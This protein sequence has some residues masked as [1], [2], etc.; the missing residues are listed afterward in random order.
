MFIPPTVI[1]GLQL[2]IPRLAD[3]NRAT[4]LVATMLAAV[5]GLI[6]V[7]C[8]TSPLLNN[9]TP[10]KNQGVQKVNVVVSP[11]NATLSPSEIQQFTANVSGTANTAVIWSASAGFINSDGVYTAPASDSTDTVTINAISL[12]NSS[13]V[14][15]ATV[16]IQKK[17]KTPKPTIT[18]TSVAGGEQGS[19]YSQ[20][21]SASGG[22]QPY[23]WR[24][25][26]GSL[27]AGLTMSAD[28]QIAGVPTTAGTFSFGVSVTDTQ[29]ST[30]QQAY[31]L[32]IA[33]GTNFDG[34]AE[35]PRVYLN[36]AL[37][38][39]PAPGAVTP[40]AAG[41]DLQSVLNNANCGDTIALQAGATFT[42]AYYLRAKACDEQH[43]ITIRTNTAD[44]NLPSEGTRMTPCYA[45]VASLP[46]RPSYPCTA[47][48][49]VL[50]QILGKPGMSL[51]SID[52]GANHYRLIG[53]ELTRPVGTGETDAL[54]QASG[55]ADHLIFD[56]LWL[57]GT[58]HDDT[59]RGIYL[60]GV[61]NAAVVDSYFSDFHCTSVTGACTDSQDVSGGNGDYPGGPYKIVNNFL[62]AAAESILFGGGGATTTTPTDIEIR[63][64]HFFKPMTWLSGQPGFVGGPSGNAFV[65]KNHFEL[66]NASRVLL[67]GNILENTWGGFSQEGYSILMT[68]RSKVS[69][70]GVNECP[71]CQVTDVTIRYNTI[72]HVGAG[73]QMANC[74]NGATN[75]IQAAYGERYSIHDVTVDDIQL[76]KYYGAGVLALILNAWSTN[77]LKDINISHVTGFPDNNLLLLTNLTSHPQM[78]GFVFADNLVLTAR[79]PIWSGGAGPTNCAAS[80]KPKL[81]LDTCFSTYGFV[82]NG[83]IAPPSAF[84]PSTWPSGNMFPPSVAAVGFT[85]Y[86][87]G[88]GGNYQLLSSSPYATAGTDGKPLG[89]DVQAINSAIAG[90]Y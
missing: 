8:A 40:V 61:T 25:I 80:D 26:S 56:R 2:D 77:V 11:D 81:S 87:N 63:H 53:L 57:H 27:P 52:S 17:S 86:N 46:G 42:G 76:K 1:S 69:S 66:K 62:E 4:K 3:R 39:T 34:P 12:A 88:N 20:G 15:S 38:E 64:N 32:A 82:R 54:I 14:A 29:N 83:L 45:G 44:S 41:A 19:A 22:T 84:G 75:Q 90:V 65:V 36:T 37:S 59:K 21:L 9:A 73:F 70:T 51:F 50:A 67:E 10:Q 5:A 43:W 68:P 85:N 78:S 72:S 35:L 47:P 28:G 60:D 55:T 48:K 24:A 89:A 79:Y 7:G 13:H 33:P 18:T 30:A 71:T 16:K 31:S 74:M 58:I 23:T 49:K 6:A